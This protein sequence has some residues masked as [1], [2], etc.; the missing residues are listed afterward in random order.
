[1]QQLGSFPAFYGNRR[2]NT[3]YPKGPRLIDT[4]R[5][6]LAFYGEGFVAPRTTP[7][8]GGPPLVVCPRLL[9]QYNR[10]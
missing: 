9:I 5:N 4:F 8:A 1:V 2:F 7:K 10:S 6:K 3:V